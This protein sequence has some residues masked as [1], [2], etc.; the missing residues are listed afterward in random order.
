[1]KKRKKNRTPKNHITILLAD[2]PIGVDFDRVK[3]HR[4]FSQ[5]WKNFIVNDKAKFEIKITSTSKRIDPIATKQ[6]SKQLSIACHPD[7]LRKYRFRTLNYG[8][9]KVMSNWLFK[10]RRYLIHASAVKN[11]R[12]QAILFTG[13]VKS[14]KSTMIK[15][16]DKYTPLADDTIFITIQNSKVFCHTTPFDE[17]INFP[18]KPEK[19]L[20][21]DLFYLQ[22]DTSCYIKRMP[23]EDRI[24]KTIQLFVLWYP[25]TNNRSFERL[26]TSAKAISPYLPIQYLHFT[27][28]DET[29][30]FLLKYYL[31][32]KN[33]RNARKTP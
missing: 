3:W 29:Q 13:P 9:K 15:I 27:N 6:T 25:S 10:K 32:N 33:S 14:G 1:M 12:K 19:V 31:H 21:R 30:E 20:V 24:R 16:V 23:K 17:K 8:L 2:L 28:H 11:N 7:Y 18:K 5:K 26:L 4:I 22:K